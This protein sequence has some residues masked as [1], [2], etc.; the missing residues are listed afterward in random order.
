MCTAHHLVDLPRD[1]SI[2]RKKTKH[3]ARSQHIFTRSSVRTQYP[4][5]W[6]SNM[7]GPHHGNVDHPSGN[8]WTGPKR[9][10]SRSDL[11]RTVTSARLHPVQTEPIGPA[12]P[13]VPCPSCDEGFLIR[14]ITAAA[15]LTLAVTYR[16]GGLV[17]P[18]ILWVKPT[19]P[20]PCVPHRAPNQPSSYSPTSLETHPGQP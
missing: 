11:P 14:W 9:F 8:S 3:A 2:A 13:A 15:A 19:M 17:V 12:D 18:G 20:C 4:G 10:E 5:V 7:T 16:Q 6:Y 1:R